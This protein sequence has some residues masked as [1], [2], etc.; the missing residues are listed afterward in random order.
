MLP[1]DMA[2]GLIAMGA[3]VAVSLGVPA[4]VAA[5]PNPLKPTISVSVNHKRIT[6]S[7]PVVLAGKV[8]GELTRTEV[9]LYSSPYPY[10]TARLLAHTTTASNGSYSFTARPDRN[11]RYRVTVPGSTAQ[12]ATS[13][14]VIAPVKFKY[15]DLPLGRIKIAIFVTHPADVRWWH[16]KARWWFAGPHGHFFSAGRQ[17]RA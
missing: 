9:D 14:G 11:T 5:T 8:K 10:R 15:K 7:R 16:P 6:G 13:V 4:G 1:T 2:R 12:A 3:A 17:P